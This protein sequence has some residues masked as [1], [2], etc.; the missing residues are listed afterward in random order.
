MRVYLLNLILSIPILILVI[1]GSN[2]N[3][4]FGSSPN[5]F[6]PIQCSIDVR[7][8]DARGVVLLNFC[9]I[10]SDVHVGDHFTI[11]ATIL[12]YSPNSIKISSS[13]PFCNNP[14]SVSFDKNVNITLGPSLP[15]CKPSIPERIL[16]PGQYAE[17]SA[18]PTRGIESFTASSTGQTTAILKLAYSQLNNTM[19]TCSVSEPFNFNIIS[20]SSQLTKSNNSNNPATV[21]AIQ[22]PK[23]NCDN[24]SPGGVGYSQLPCRPPFIPDP[25]DPNRCGK[26]EDPLPKK[27]N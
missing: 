1:I 23:T 11:N 24:A 5:I 21:Q 2:V 22:A 19:K 26:I 4:I 20:S 15:A 16:N 8:I 3:I 10:P 27:S 18:L 13:G 17:L 25:D 7:G 14:L 12:N 6:S 9:T